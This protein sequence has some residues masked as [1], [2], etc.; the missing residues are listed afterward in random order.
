M[1]TFDTISGAYAQK[2]LVQQ[3]AAGRLVEL[4]AIPPAADV[5]DVACGPGHITAEL[6]GRTRG[7]VVGVDASAGMIRQA[8]ARYP[9][10][11]FQPVPAE[12]IEYIGAFDRVFCNSALQWFSRPLAAVQHI[13]RTLRPGGQAG[14]ACPGTAEWS[15]FYTR[16]IHSV[17]ARPGIAGTFSRWRNPWFFLKT[18]DEYRR[19]FEDAGFTT[20]YLSIDHELTWFTVEE[21]YAVYLSGAGNGFTQPQHYDTIIP[22][23][24]IEA[25]NAAVKEAFEQA[26]VDGKV[27]LDFNRVYYV[28][29]KKE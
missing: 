25:F 29:E 23:G 17:V 21:A 16:M 22:G 27:P 14:I 28:G 4:L 18:E 15:P 20:V 6:R 10:I 12:E 11:E 9:N 3:K 8:R 1:S 19:F 13:H 2:S 24:Y 7:R 5:M 26:A